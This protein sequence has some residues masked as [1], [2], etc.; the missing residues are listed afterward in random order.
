M[1]RVRLATIWDLDWHGKDC[2]Q[3]G[4]RSHAGRNSNAIPRLATRV[5]IMPSSPAN[6][7]H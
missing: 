3:E 7:S 4:R 1:I 2:D 6:K 5:P